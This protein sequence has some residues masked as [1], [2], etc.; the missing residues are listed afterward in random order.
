MNAR[1]LLLLSL[2]LS[3]ANV[4][5]AADAWV[6]LGLARGPVAGCNPVYTWR[7]IAVA[8]NLDADEVEVGVVHFSNGVTASPDTVALQRGEAAVIPP[9]GAATASVPVYVA[10]IAVPEGV[11]IESRLEYL[12]DNP[13]STAPPA[14]G[15]AGKIN[16]P[17]F[18]RLAAAGE[19]QIHFGS[20]LGLQN[21]RVN[22]GIY[23]AGTVE[24]RAVVGVHRPGCGADATV[25]TEVRVPPDSLIQ[26]TVQQPPTCSGL[27]GA[28][29]AYVTYAT[30]TVDQPSLSYTTPV[31]NVQPPNLS[32]AV[33]AP[34]S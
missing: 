15:P 24:A 13:C 34:S 10:K 22:V 19:R 4:S 17:V 28:V 31:S 11:A 30:V 27:G 12:Y 33:A 23:N 1:R 29:P 14:P 32:F 18:R 8:H 16:F 9:L 7:A 3:I 25:T 20:D 6:V 5:E 21:A 2:L 26:A